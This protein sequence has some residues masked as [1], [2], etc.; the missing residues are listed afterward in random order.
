LG[1]AARYRAERV[2][3]GYDRLVNE[4]PLALG[5]IGL[6]VGAVLAATAPRT[7]HEDRAMG[8][9]S[10]RLKESVKEA[11]REQFE[12]ASSSVSSSLHAARAEASVGDGFDSDIDDTHLERPPSVETSRPP[13]PH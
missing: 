10:H 6:A 12:R 3:T 1:A 11:G 5:A 4:Q 8:D 9:A 7:R 13:A 2:R